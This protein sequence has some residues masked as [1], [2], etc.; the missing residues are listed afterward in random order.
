MNIKLIIDECP[1]DIKHQT[2]DEE[3]NRPAQRAVVVK[4]GVIE[5]VV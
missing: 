2:A 4:G 3:V 5:G 1:I